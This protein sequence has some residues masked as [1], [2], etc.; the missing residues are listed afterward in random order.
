MKISE[1]E[2]LKQMEKALNSLSGVQRESLQ[3]KINLQKNKLNNMYISQSLSIGKL[4]GKLFREKNLLNGYLKIQ[5]TGI[6]MHEQIKYSK[7]KIYFINQRLKDAVFVENEVEELQKISGTFCVNIKDIK[8]DPIVKP[9]E[10][11]IIVDSKVLKKLKLINQEI[12]FEVENNREIEIIIKETDK[13]VGF[14]FFTI[15]KMM[16]FSDE[17]INFQDNVVL[18]CNFTFE[19]QKKLRRGNAEIMAYR[20]F[21]HD[22]QV[23]SNISP[24]F[25]SVCDK[26]C[27]FE[28]LK[29]KNCNVNCH[30]ACADILLFW[31]KMKFHKEKDKYSKE[32]VLNKLT[33]SGLRYC[34]FCGER[35][36]IGAKACICEVCQKKYHSK[37]EPSIFADCQLTLLQREKLCGKK[38][39]EIITDKIQEKVS[40][41]DFSLIKVLGRGSFGK[42]ML[43]LH[44]NTKIIYALKILKKERVINANNITYL[45]LEKHVLVEVSKNRHPFLMTMEY[46]FQDLYNVYFCTEYLAGGDLLHH[47][48]KRLFNDTQNKIWI[49]QIVLGIEHLH[50]LNIIYRDLKLDNIMLT[51]EGNVKIAD[52]GL[53]K[54]KIGFNTVTY[55]YCGTLDTIAPEVILQKGY[56]KDCDWW[57]L[58][59]V[60]Y[61]LYESYPPFE[62]DTPVELTNSILKNEIIYQNTPEDAQD[63]INKLLTKSPNVRLGYGEKDAEEIKSHHF[64]KNIDFDKI[65][66]KEVVSEFMPGDKFENFDDEFT[67]QPI[68][69]TPSPEMGKYENFFINFN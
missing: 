53:C 27:F 21:G 7:L 43:A 59:V 24:Y 6:D 69:I 28:S 65:Y 23:F 25:C 56:T 19:K 64:F 68:I 52:F 18:H 63:L 45:Q 4:E 49:A 29:C 40:I 13:I 9:N 57:S 31:C 44:K 41:K 48:S 50:K 16:N 8:I 15:E 66:K 62:G 30:K 51:K 67:D 36:G 38:E 1:E 26:T 5:D 61:E 11:I 47:I 58:G 32:H 55:T 34:D 35:I 42:V 54:E 14:L 10:I 17:M 46:C 22:L 20:K 39:M 37:C 33:G 60:I 12:E 3:F 2:K